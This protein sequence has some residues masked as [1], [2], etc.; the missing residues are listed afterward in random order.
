M[1]A[2]GLSV[3]ATLQQH[4]PLNNTLYYVLVFL[5]TVLYYSLAY[6]KTETSPDSGNLRSA[7]YTSN[8]QAIMISLWLYAGLL[9]VFS[10]WL[11]VNHFRFLFTLY[12]YEYALIL[13]FPCVA[14]LYYG[15]PLP[16]VHQYNLRNVGWLKPFV[17]GFIWAGMVTVY[18][19]MFGRLLHFTHY[20][21][22][23]ITVLLFLKNLMFVTVLCI[24]FDIKDYAM[25]YNRQLKTFVV[26]AG[27]RRTLFYI[28]IPITV[29]GLASFIAFATLQH[30]SFFKIVI[31]TIPFIALLLV[32]YSLQARRS[33]FYYLVI[34]DGLMLVKACCGTLA[35]LYF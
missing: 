1:C 26:K 16:I 27:L 7:W 25:D 10:A 29:L 20:F 30:F 11:C 33:I 21:P 31:N 32:A 9:L 34:I 8:L 24:L 3:E 6:I 22:G 17:I 18:P 12:W 13:V 5:G 23:T 2:V 28:V 35:M 15:V 19:I 14:A 4:Y